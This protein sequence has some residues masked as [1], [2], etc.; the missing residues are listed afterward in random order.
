MRSRSSKQT[1]PA[2]TLVEVMAVIASISTMSTLTFVAFTS[3]KRFADGI[4]Q[5]ANSARAHV[6]R[7]NGTKGAVATPVSQAK[8]RPTRVPGSY[9][10]NFTPAV[11]DP[12]G[13]AQRLASLVGGSVSKVYTLGIYG[14]ALKV[15]NGSLNNLAMDPA[16]KQIEQMQY[17]YPSAV[18]TNIQRVFCNG[19]APGQDSGA[20]T[21]IYG[22]PSTVYGFYRNNGV[23]ALITGRITI[24]ASTGATIP[25]A[26]MDT[27][28]DKT[29]PDLFVVYEQDFVNGGAGNN[30]GDAEGH[31]THV[32]G[33][34]GAIDQTAGAGVVGVYP[35]APLYNLKVMGKNNS[36]L[37]GGTAQDVYDA[38]TF[39]IANSG[40]IRVCLMAFETAAK[41]ANMN[42]LVD[43]AG[44]SGVLMVAAAGNAGVAFNTVSPAS[45][46][47]AIVVGAM[48]DIDGSCESGKAAPDE[49]LAGYNNTG[50]FDFVA[51]GGEGA[52]AASIIRSTT[53]NPL[54]RYSTLLENVN[55]ATAINAV[56]TS[57]AAAHV[58][59][60]LAM[61]LDPQ[62]S[63]G[64]VVGNANP[65]FRYQMY[66]KA[67]AVTALRNLTHNN[68]R[69]Q[70]VNPLTNSAWSVSGGMPKV[71]SPYTKVLNNDNVGGFP[72]PNIFRN[73]N[74]V[75][76]TSTLTKFPG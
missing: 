44:N 74:T 10:V 69:F 14:F 46:G 76:P 17:V 73:D 61:V 7:G 35:G 40:N 29:H 34:V 28:I 42:A 25:V 39:V 58:A 4:E 65:T 8:P 38:L 16:V 51:P 24:N 45:A 54:N 30:P 70:M 68:T 71:I 57:F 3:A 11:K 21:T 23:Q 64:Y 19:M 27:G 13:E 20:T 9:F 36:D 5:Q 59:G 6:A 37:F 33:V 72:V 48:V 43:L 49:T 47:Q 22:A 60:L 56:G 18:P 66:N 15:G 52:T 62:T 1:R 26:I 31:G 63:V 41:D 67:T 2:V 55:G 12:Y 32:A 75:D 53:A 50:N